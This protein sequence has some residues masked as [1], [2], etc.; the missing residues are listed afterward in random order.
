M[1]RVLT[2]ILILPFL[3]SGCQTSEPE[4][5][6]IIIIMSDDMGYS[7]LG[8]YGGEINTPQ[9]DDLAAGGL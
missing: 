4:K 6:N 1:K 8:C 2:S 7:D 9:L 3:L 5:P